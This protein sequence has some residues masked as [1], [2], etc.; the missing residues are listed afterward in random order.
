MTK[1]ST[2]SR[3]VIRVLVVLALTLPV[4][5]CSPV[6][7]QDVFSRESESAVLLRDAKRVAAV[8]LTMEVR[9][10]TV[11]DEFLERVGVDFGGSVRGQVARNDRP[12]QNAKMIVEVFKVQSTNG[13]QT[14]VRVG[15]KKVATDS[16][17]EFRVP[18]RDLVNGDTRKEIQNGDVAALRIEATGK[19]GKP[20]DLVRVVTSTTLGGLIQ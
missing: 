15:R 9:F 14:I 4:L 16:A 13:G 7:A 1:S 5:V 20:V 10:L 11:G 3:I 18:M 12:V 2:V 8:Q 19:N 17:G 6:A